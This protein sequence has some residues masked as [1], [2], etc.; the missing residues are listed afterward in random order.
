M[1]ILVIG[2]GLIGKQRAR[3]VFA[4]KDRGVVLAGTVDPTPR[5]PALY[6]DAPHFRSLDAVPEAAYDAAILAL[7]HS[8][9]EQLSLRVLAANKHILLEK[10]L[11]T[12]LAAARAIVAAAA[13]VKTPSFIGCNYRFLPTMGVLYERLAQGA[14]GAV[15]GVDIFMG[16][17]GNPRSA[18]EWKLSREVAGGGV[19]I[20]PGTHLF[21]LLLTLLPEPKLEHVSAT[22]GFWKTGIEEDAVAVFRSQ[23][24]IATVRVS[25]LRW[26][27]TLRI[28]LLGEDGDAVIEG[29]GGNYGAMT[30]RLRT[31]GGAEESADFGKDNKSLD[32]ELEHVALR[33]MGAPA[34]PGARHAATMEEALRVA[35]LLD[36]MYARIG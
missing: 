18:E 25:L 35:E 4:M 7:P 11:G 15:R 21:D 10:P 28:E 27:N 29:R 20:D 17:G 2:H 14:L 16:H 23:Q 34:E 8:L 31:K 32:D 33:W 13:R 5:D 1:K 24:T 19:L 3:K 12:S 36:A 6:G 30:I 22:R 9:A 26:V